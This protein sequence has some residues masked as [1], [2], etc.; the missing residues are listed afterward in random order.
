M[1]AKQKAEAVE[2]SLRALPSNVVPFP[3]ARREISI[4]IPEP[5]RTK[6]PAAS[7]ATQFNARLLILLG[8]CTMSASSALLA[9]HLLH[10]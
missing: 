7:T 4:S 6:Q 10:G 5:H 3:R 9:V 8:I 1:R 2:I